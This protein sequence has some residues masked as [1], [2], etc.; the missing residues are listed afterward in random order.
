MCLKQV[1]VKSK[2]HKM[3]SMKVCKQK[4]TQQI[5]LSQG[6]GNCQKLWETWQ[7]CTLTFPK[8]TQKMIMAI[9]LQKRGVERKQMLTKTQS[10]VVKTS[11]LVT[12]ELLNVKK[13][14]AKCS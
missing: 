6:P 13:L 7:H 12:K 14:K 3:F 8:I 10:E 2:A 5:N 9:F 4:S 11:S 1:E